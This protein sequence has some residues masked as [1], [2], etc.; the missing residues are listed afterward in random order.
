MKTNRIILFLPSTL[1]GI[2]YSLF[3]RDPFEHVAVEV[4][5]QLWDSGLGRGMF[6]VSDIDIK[7][8]PHL[9][10]EFD[11]DIVDWLV[12]HSGRKHKWKGFWGW[13]FN[14][15]PGR[16]LYNF[17]MG[18]LALLS[19][20]IVSGRM[21]LRVTGLSLLAAIIEYERKIG[22]GS[23]GRL[24]NQV[25]SAVGFSYSDQV[26]KALAGPS[27]IEVSN[28]VINTILL[29]TGKSTLPEALVAVSNSAAVRLLVTTKMYRLM[30]FVGRCNASCKAL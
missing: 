6:S 2:L 12:A 16:G 20:G 24:I 21:P 19:A 1:L 7:S 25:L 26:A 8:R 3:Y 23:H 13:L 18:W 14:A 30:A 27:G 28:A 11:G 17:E 29:A 5:G 22:A 4:G 9:S 15:K 10:L